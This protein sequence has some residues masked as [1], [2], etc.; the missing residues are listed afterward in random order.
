MNFNIIIQFFLTII[1]ICQSIELTYDFVRD[2]E[3]QQPDDKVEDATS[4]PSPV[5]NKVRSLNSLYAIPGFDIFT[6]VKNILKDRV[7]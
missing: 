2:G 5:V 3:V 7:S 6:D 1:V 4:T